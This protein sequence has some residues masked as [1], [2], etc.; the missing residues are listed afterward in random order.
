MKLINSPRKLAL[1]LLLQQALL[2]GCSSVSLLS[3]PAPAPV[4]P[5]LPAQARQID[6]ATH[7]QRAQTD[8]ETWLQPLTAPSSPAV[9]ASAPT[10]R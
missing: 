3:K 5:P 7:S 4:V 1:M 9:P 10:R 6:S 2:V 8:T